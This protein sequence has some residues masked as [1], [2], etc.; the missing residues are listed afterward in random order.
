MKMELRSDNRNIAD[1]SQSADRALA[2]LDLLGA[3]QE[4]GVREIARELELAASIV[5]R[6]INTLCDRGYVER[7]PGGQK[8]RV[9]YRAFQVGRS[10]LAHGDLHAVSLPELRTMAE[11]DQINAYLGVLRGGSVVYLEALQSKGP[12]AITST[13]GSSASLHSTA[14]GKALLAELPDTEIAAILGSEPFQRLT[15]KTKTTLDEFMKEIQEVR[16]TGYAVSDEENI[17]GVFAAGA[18]VRDASGQAVASVSGAVPRHQLQSDGIDNLCHIVVGAAQRIS[19]R[20]GASP[21][22]LRTSRSAPQ[23]S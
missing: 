17:E 3:G 1:V 15:P 6:M 18:V 10:Y 4:L 2:V 8:Y 20:L 11:R 13:Q 7:G 21:V 5:Q 19:R 9:G 23:L 16:R 14:F 22:M 12:I